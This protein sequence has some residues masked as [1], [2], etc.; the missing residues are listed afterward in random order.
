MT[1]IIENWD[2]I[3]AVLGI[4]GTACTGLVATF[5]KSKC[6]FL[7]WV[8]KICDWMSVVNTAENKAKIAKAT[9]NTKKK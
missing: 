9:K 6:R 7:V 5:G 2:K 8:V 1:W 3:F 4:M